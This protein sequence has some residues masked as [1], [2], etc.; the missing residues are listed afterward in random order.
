MFSQK[1]YFVSANRSL[2]CFA[3]G[4]PTAVNLARQI[5]I[6]CDSLGADRLQD[7]I[8]RSAASAPGS[9]SPNA[10]GDEV[11]VADAGR[12]DYFWLVLRR[13]GTIPVPT[14]LQQ[15]C[16]CT[17]QKTAALFL[18][19]HLWRPDR[20]ISELKRLALLTLAFAAN[21]E[22]SFVAAPFDI[23]M[24][25]RNSSGIVE[26]THDSTHEQFQIGLEGLFAEYHG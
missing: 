18:P 8:Y 24:I 5:S 17:G 6:D 26:E 11:L 14:V 10:I 20:P 3:A 7:A 13:P 23:V 16:A 2:V 21:E 9:P 19:R 1:K 12:L 25:E 22:P 15:Q 4:G